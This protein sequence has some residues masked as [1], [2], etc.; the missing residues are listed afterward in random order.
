[1]E[2]PFL[3]F[4]FLQSFFPS[5]THWY[6][7]VTMASLLKPLR[8]NIKSK[9][10]SYPTRLSQILAGLCSHTD[11]CGGPFPLSE[12]STF[13][14][15]GQLTLD[16]EGQLIECKQKSPL[17]LM[18]QSLQIYHK[19]TYILDFLDIFWVLNKKNL[20]HFCWFK[21][22]PCEEIAWVGM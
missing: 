4:P 9:Q 16:T 12:A 1:M 7:A 17:S 5:L 22:V 15:R 10:R 11:I 18:H 2:A 20:H 8:E 6:K 3:H 21:Q 19:L 13:E 14:D